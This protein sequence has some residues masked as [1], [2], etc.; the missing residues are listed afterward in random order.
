MI[1]G[2]QDFYYCVAD[3]E[4]ALRFY[5]DLLGIPVENRSEWWSALD[6]GG[7]RLGLHW[8]GGEAVP[9]VPGDDHGPH[10]GGQLTL[11]VRDIAAM[12]DRLR[13]AGTSV[14]GD[15]K[16]RPWGHLVT[17]RDPDGNYLTL[18]QPKTVAKEQAAA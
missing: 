9:E 3:M 8:T 5:R 16:D 12:L 14:L 6:I 13:K 1:S 7:V 18:M 15:I 11:R 10:A 17:I 2:V 4:R